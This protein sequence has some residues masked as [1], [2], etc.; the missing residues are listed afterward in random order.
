[1]DSTLLNGLMLFTIGL[2]YIGLTSKYK[3]I[4]MIAVVPA[5]MLAFE[6]SN[7][8]SVGFAALAVFN[9]YHSVFGGE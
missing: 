3:M 2:T 9:G 8:A 6:F 7:W 4:S 1:M 5:L